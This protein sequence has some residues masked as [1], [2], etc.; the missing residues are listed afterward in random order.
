MS[1]KY[2]NNCFRVG[3][4]NE[5]TGTIGLYFIKNEI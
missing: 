3:P 2:N 4:A 5:S 1:Y